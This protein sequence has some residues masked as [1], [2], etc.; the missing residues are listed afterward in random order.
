VVVDVSVVL[1]EPREERLFGLLDRVLIALI[2]TG[3]VVQH[4]LNGLAIDLL[5]FLRLLL[6]LFLDRS[7]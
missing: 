1:L 3:I 7:S 6:L 5:G 2:V 4:L